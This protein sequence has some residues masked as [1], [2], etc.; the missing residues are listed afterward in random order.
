MP[1]QLPHPDSAIHLYRRLLREAT[2]VAPL[3]RPWVTDRIRTKFRDERRPSLK[4]AHRSLRFLQSANSGHINRMLHLCFLATGR[5]GKRRR[6]LASSAL[7][8][9]PAVD[10]DALKLNSLFATT[11]P[12]YKTKKTA[13]GNS[14][15]KKHQSYEEPAPPGWL[16]KWDV[17]KIKAVAEAQV[18]SSNTNWPKQMRKSIDPAKVLPKENAWG[19]PFKP[20]LMKRKEQKHYAKILADLMPPL[21]QGEWDMLKDL[22]FG[23]AETKMFDI[24]SRR[25]MAT[26][27]V[28]TQGSKADTDREW[29][30]GAYVTKPVRAV[31]R[32]SSRKFKSLSGTADSDPRGP[33]RP[34]GVKS[35]KPRRLR[36]SIYAR[37]WE[38]T[39]T[40]W[41]NPNGKI[42]VTFGQARRELSPASTSDLQ[43]F[44]GV[45]TRGAPA[46]STDVH[47]KN[48]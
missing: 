48:G 32:G 5:L 22:S 10:S 27:P 19:R 39:P 15:R 6:Q 42:Q 29:N 47:K 18:R 30:W 2:Y 3:C 43:F 9:D 8:K 35:F 1:F 36:R 40:L 45:D 44:S 14:N 23:Q 25:T 24:P 33:G 26:T 31:E 38:A 28:A 11:T 37:V 17:D 21:P 13:T 41:K 7:A 4:E 20:K 12:D 16:D 34:I 46:S